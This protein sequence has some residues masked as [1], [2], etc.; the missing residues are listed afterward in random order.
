MFLPIITTP[1]QKNFDGYF[2]PDFSIIS[3][4]VLRTSSSIKKEKEMILFL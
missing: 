2:S 1:R 4:V 3:N